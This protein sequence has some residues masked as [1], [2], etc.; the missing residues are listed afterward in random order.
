[1]RG[2][3]RSRRSAVSKSQ[4]SKL[5]KRSRRVARCSASAMVSRSVASWRTRAPPT[6]TP[7]GAV[8]RPEWDMRL[9]VDYVLGASEDSICEEYGLVSHQWH[10]ILNDIGFLGKVA[11]LKKELE[12]DGATFAL[13]AKVQA[14][15]LIDESFRMA[16]DADVDPRVRAKLIGDTVRWAGYDKNAAV[17]DGTG[18]FS[19][20]INLNGKRLG[21]TFDGEAEDVAV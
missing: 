13:K 1:M 6:M 16:M 5:V 15:V 18:G 20:N 2:M 11:A 4:L 3:C 21:D 10:R 9:V 14:E 8:V 7:V 12:K 19:I 17:A